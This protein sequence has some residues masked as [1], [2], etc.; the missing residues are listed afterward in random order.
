MQKKSFS[1]HI[2]SHSHNAQAYYDHKQL[3]AR[4]EFLSLWV[5]LPICEIFCTKK[6]NYYCL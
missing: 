2:R 5:V 6:I 4:V 1:K 3:R